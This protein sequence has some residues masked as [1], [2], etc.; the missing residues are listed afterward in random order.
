VESNTIK[1]YD[2]TF[3]DASQT[4]FYV[5]SNGGSA[6]V[7]RVGL[8][9]QGTADDDRWMSASSTLFNVTDDNGVVHRGS[10]SLGRFEFDDKSLTGF[11]FEGNNVTVTHDQ[12]EKKKN[13][14]GSTDTILSQKGSI[15]TVLNAGNVGRN[16]LAFDSEGMHQGRVAVL[17]FQ[18]TTLKAGE[19]SETI[20][21][22]PNTLSLKIETKE[23]DTA[24]T[25]YRL[26]SDQDT[27]NNKA[28]VETGSQFEKKGNDYVMKNGSFRLEDGKNHEMVIGR[29][30]YGGVSV[31]KGGAGGAESNEANEEI[32][33]RID[34]SGKITAFIGRV[35]VQDGEI[36]LKSNTILNDANVQANPNTSN[37]AQKRK[38]VQTDGEGQ[39]YLSN[40]VK[41]DSSASHASF[42]FGVAVHDVM[43]KQVHDSSKFKG[44]VVVL[45]S[46]NR[47]AGSFQ[48]M[49]NAEVKGEKFT[50]RYTSRAFNRDSTLNGALSEQRVII[51][52]DEKNMLTQGVVK[53]RESALE[54]APLIDRSHGGERRNVLGR[55]RDTRTTWGA[56][57][58][59]RAL[60]TAI[61][62]R[63]SNTF[64]ATGDLNSL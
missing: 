52:R 1:S 16:V 19:L 63:R 34:P 7:D 21:L 40:A 45:D 41:I 22:K 28:I 44:D 4:K 64:C 59:A 8:R 18:Q 61:L 35:Y 50:G 29:N 26:T 49:G 12:F 25:L 57:P 9:L 14:E 6:K 33:V 27:N 3:A 17:P 56:T 5:N 62:S 36:K 42:S 15:Q 55:V 43:E 46:Q 11:S 2:F 24:K 23:G 60:C 32:N 10:A 13:N 39:T 38:I 37:Y 30:S 47:V 20:Q 31:M 58:S 54:T 48:F 51:Q 53:E